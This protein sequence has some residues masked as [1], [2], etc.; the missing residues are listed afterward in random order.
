M[1]NR[2]D[3]SKGIELDKMEIP[4]K[5]TPSPAKSPSAKRESKRAVSP[6]TTSTFTN[7]LVLFSR[8]KLFVGAALATLV[9]GSGVVY[10]ALKGA[11]WGQKRSEANYIGRIVYEVGTSMGGKHDVRFTLSVPFRSA[12]QKNA[13]MHKMPSI[14]RELSV[15]GNRPDV[16]RSVEQK[17]L[18]TLRK[19]IVSTVH[20]LTGVPTKALDV[21]GLSVD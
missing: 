6:R 13:L 3:A 7:L 19:H 5:T 16:A 11:S 10:L 1:E 12:A 20:S 9:V 4:L 21:E 2:D 18:H 17:D 8:R 15:S 14:N